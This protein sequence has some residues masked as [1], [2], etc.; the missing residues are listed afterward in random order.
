[1]AVL[2]AKEDLLSA[3]HLRGLVEIM[4]TPAES[5]K[6]SGCRL[7]KGEQLGQAGKR[8]LTRTRKREAGGREGGDGGQAGPVQE[9]IK[10]RSWKGM[11]R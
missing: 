6:V 4:P 7:R 10:S 1:M 8:I 2:G 3:E 11:M 5:R 9:E